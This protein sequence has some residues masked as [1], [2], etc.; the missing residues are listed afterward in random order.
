MV[1]LSS[2]HAARLLGD[3]LDGL[4]D[5]RSRDDEW[6]RQSNDVLV[7]RLGKKPSVLERIAERPRIPL[8]AL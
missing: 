6:R 2:K 3:D 8:L 5:L 1:L 4:V 7:R